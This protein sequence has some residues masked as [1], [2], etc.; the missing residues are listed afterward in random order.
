[1]LAIVGIVAAV[2]IIDFFDTSHNYSR[3]AARLVYGLI[4]AR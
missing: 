1:M 3:S 4:M 2:L